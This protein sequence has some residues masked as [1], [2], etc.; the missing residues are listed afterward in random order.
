MARNISG[1]DGKAG[2]PELGGFSGGHVPN[3][4]GKLQTRR[5]E[6]HN[7]QHLGHN[8]GDH[9]SRLD[10]PASRDELVEQARAHGMGDE[11]IEALQ[12]MPDSH[13]ASFDELRQG[14]GWEP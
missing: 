13:Y 5:V 9:V 10:F 6:E 1:R 3:A 11:M 7:F 12:H 14:L 2:N 8:W 4:P